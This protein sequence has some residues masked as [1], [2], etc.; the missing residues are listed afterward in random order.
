MLLASDFER[1]TSVFNAASVL[2]R[3]VLRYPTGIN[4]S[5]GRSS[6]DRIQVDGIGVT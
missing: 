3:Y 4:Y 2:P 6:V 1:I 5:A